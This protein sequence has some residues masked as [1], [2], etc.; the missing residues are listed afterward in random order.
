MAAS[1][2]MVPL[3]TP[4]HDFELPSA[5]GTTVKLADLEGRVFA[6][7]GI[8]I[9]GENWLIPID[10]E[11][12]SETD[13]ESE[14]IS[15]KSVT[16]QVA[17]SRQL[18]LVI[19]DACRNNPFDAKMQRL[20]LKR[21]VPRGFARVEP[22]GNVLVAYA[23]KD[24]TTANDGSGRNSPFTAALLRNI[25]KPGLEINFLFRNVRVDVMA[26]TANGQQPFVYGSLS[27]EMIYLT[28]PAILPQLSPTIVVSP[29]TEIKPVPPAEK[30]PISVDVPK[31]ADS[32]VATIA[33]P[34][35]SPVTKFPQT[36]DPVHDSLWKQLN[37]AGF[38]R[39][40][41]QQVLKFLRIK[42]PHRH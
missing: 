2:L 29:S 1:S 21:D 38:G 9:G 15:L 7:H 23:A 10:A 4:A 6:G 11:L 32:I 18:G 25:E 28:P 34:Q 16:L 22:V 40:L 8:E 30:P 35:L 41:L 19:L 20:T 17:K 36:G 33:R 24:G 26:A 42:L 39:K 12:Q 37:D 13:A 3:G 14:S 27:N 31:P 5:D